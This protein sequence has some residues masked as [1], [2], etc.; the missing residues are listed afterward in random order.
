[1]ISDTPYLFQLA[2]TSPLL[3]LLKNT[4]T[5]PRI[6]QSVK[7][8][9]QSQLSKYMTKTPLSSCQGVDAFVTKLPP[10]QQQYRFFSKLASNAAPVPLIK[11]WRL[12][13][14]DFCVP[15]ETSR[16]QAMEQ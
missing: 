13:G 10:P 7:L 6:L 16:K 8:L 5:S 1:M 15:T 9:S 3:E 12:N 14:E 11:C 2:S 4:T